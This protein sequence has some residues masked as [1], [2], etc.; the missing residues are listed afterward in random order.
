MSRDKIFQ[1][2]KETTI[3]NIVAIRENLTRCVDEG[4]VDLNAEYYNELLLLEDEGSLAQSWD[5]LEEVITKAKTLEVDV[6]AWLANHGQT[7]ISIP[8]PRPPVS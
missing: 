6:A 8:W 7:S 4:M 5:E 3:S 1:V 2:A